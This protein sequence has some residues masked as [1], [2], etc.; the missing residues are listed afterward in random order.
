MRFE[1]NP[2]RQTPGTET[3]VEVPLDYA[4]R[5]NQ[6]KEAARKVIDR[7]EAQLGGE[8][9]LDV[10]NPE[11]WD[12][13]G[14]IMMNPS[15]Y[16]LASDSDTFSP[17]LR[18]LYEVFARDLFNKLLNEGLLPA[19]TREVFV[20]GLTCVKAATGVAYPGVGEESTE[21]LDFCKSLIDTSNQE[22]VAL[23]RA[24]DLEKIQSVLLHR[25]NM[26]RVFR[27]AR[28]LLSM[29]VQDSE[30][31][32]HQILPTPEDFVA[33]SPFQHLKLVEALEPSDQLSIAQGAVSYAKQ[34]RGE[35]NQRLGG[36]RYTGILEHELMNV[37]A[38][39]TGSTRILLDNAAKG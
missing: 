18:Y 29:A 34:L 3:A 31:E 11:F 14:E 26:L 21:L 10:L 9:S 16:G 2:D 8:G 38:T 20:D 1:F 4:E 15:E 27:F 32:F 33:S 19:T 22:A 24:N 39:V 13:N 28:A 5:F 12:A 30:S 6:M 25:E 35:Q 36:E 23:L 17:T 37:L 7:L